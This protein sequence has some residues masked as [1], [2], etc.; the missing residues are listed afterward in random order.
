MMMKKIMYVAVIATTVG[1]VGVVVLRRAFPVGP[2][3]LVLALVPLIGLVL[4]HRSLPGSLP[5]IIF[6]AIDTG[7][8]TVPAVWGGIFFW[9]CRSH[10]RECHWRCNHRL[11][12]GL[13]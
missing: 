13:F 9:C 4:A 8:L 12:R 6:G 7:L 1:T 3:V 5:D 10:C 11:N 2:A